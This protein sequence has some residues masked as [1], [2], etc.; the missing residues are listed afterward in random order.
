MSEEV[1]PTE[2]AAET[3]PAPAAVVPKQEESTAEFAPVVRLS[4]GVGFCF[5]W[6]RHGFYSV[7]L[8]SI[9]YGVP[10]SCVF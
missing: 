4:F 8:D 7:R 6:H 5:E 3:A 1:K 2:P 9:R 10:L